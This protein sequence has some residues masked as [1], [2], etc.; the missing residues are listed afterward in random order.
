MWMIIAFFGNVQS[1]PASSSQWYRYKHIVRRLFYSDAA[2]LSS[3]ALALSQTPLLPPSNSHLSACEIELLRLSVLVRSGALDPLPEQDGILTSLIQKSL[4][5][6]ADSY[7]HDTNIAATDM[8]IT[9]LGETVTKPL[10]RNIWEVSDVASAAIPLFNIE[11]KLLAEVGSDGSLSIEGGIG[12]LQACVALMMAWMGRLP[13]DKKARWIRLRKD[14]DKLMATLTEKS[15]AIENAAGTLESRPDASFDADGVESAFEAAFGGGDLSPSRNL[16]A[17]PDA[18]AGFYRQSASLL[19]LSSTLFAAKTVHQPNESIQVFGDDFLIRIW[20]LVSNDDMRKHQ[21]YVL[22]GRSG[23]EPAVPKDFFRSI[24]ASKVMSISALLYLGAD[25]DSEKT[26]SNNAG[27]SGLALAISCI[28]SS[29]ESLCHMFMAE[30][31]RNAEATLFPTTD[32]CCGASFRPNST[33]CIAAI[34]SGFTSLSTILSRARSNLA[35]AALAHSSNAGQLGNTCLLMVIPVVEVA[36]PCIV[37]TKEADSSSELF[38]R[39][40][41]AT[42][43]HGIGLFHELGKNVDTPTVETMA[44]TAV[45]AA[46]GSPSNTY[47]DTDDLFGGLGDDAFMNIDLDNLTGQSTSASS[48]QVE[49]GDAVGE[50][51]DDRVDGLAKGKLWC[52]LMDALDAAKVSIYPPLPKK[53]G[54]ASSCI[55]FHS[56]HP[57]PLA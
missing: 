22:N 1:V 25:I 10:L 55:L 4:S 20:S 47:Q 56:S 17:G 21:L 51:V 37:Q 35:N 49:T 8:I 53:I 15:N 5:L 14:I 27:E 18:S 12:I 30:V 2:V 3:G 23:Q 26:P 24:V 28:V 33:M 43:R 13:R 45:G 48:S 32:N 36:F 16:Q 52:L 38:L 39:S 9:V 41:L 44:A 7:R 54:L 11:S 57:K 50:V 46:A 31:E 19:L 6:Q 42:L 29:L 40:V 34:S